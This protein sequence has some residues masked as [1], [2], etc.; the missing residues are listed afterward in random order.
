MPQPPS[1]RIGYAIRTFNRLLRLVER[2][3]RAHPRDEDIAALKVIATECARDLIQLRP[4]LSQQYRRN[5]Q[6]KRR[7]DWA[8]IKRAQ[9]LRYKNEKRK[10][11]QAASE[12]RLRVD[13]ASMPKLAELS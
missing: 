8:R 10:I 3:A 6:A 7:P 5:L 11:N 1:P 12:A 2:A 4:V 13:P 9:Y